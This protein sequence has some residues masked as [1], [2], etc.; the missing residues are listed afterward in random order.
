MTDTLPAGHDYEQTAFALGYAYA[1]WQGYQVESPLSGEWA[2]S[3]LPADIYRELG[4]TSEG[5]E[6]GSILD[7]WESG[8]NEFFEQD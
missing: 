3:I 1:R 6:G 8:Y 4:I 7:S 2:G 5:D